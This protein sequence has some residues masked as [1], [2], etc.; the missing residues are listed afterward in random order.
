M[1]RT[2]G[3]LRRLAGGRHLP[4][5]GRG[6]CHGPGRQKTPGPCGPGVFVPVADTGFEPVKA[7]PADLQSAPF[8]RSG[9]LP[10]HPAAAGRLEDDRTGRA[11]VDCTA[12]PRHTANRPGT[13]SV[14][15]GR[16]ARRAPARPVSGRRRRAHPVR[17]P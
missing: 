2:T 15:P 17:R 11:R 3:R 16:L 8:G 4:G 5:R 9:N 6:V 1:T 7:V 10:C 12:S 14:V 13:A